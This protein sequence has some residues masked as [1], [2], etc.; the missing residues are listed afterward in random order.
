MNSRQPTESSNEPVR[1]LI[2]ARRMRFDFSKVPRYW[3]PGRP[4]ETHLFNALNAL[5]PPGEHLFIRVCLAVFDEVQDPE[6]RR[7]VRGFLAQESSHASGHLMLVPHLEAQ[8]FPMRSLIETVER[9]AARGERFLGPHRHLALVA[10]LEHFTATLGAWAFES[11]VFEDVDPVMRDLFLWHA[12]E[13]IE[14]KCVAF[15]LLQ[16]V[17]PG[18]WYRVLGLVSS[19][20]GLFTE[21]A[22]ITGAL[23]RSDPKV[24]SPSIARDAYRSWRQGRLPIGAILRGALRYLH[25]RFH[26]RHEANLHLALTYFDTAS[27]STG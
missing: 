17:R 22:W 9:R 8:G 19:M 23:I 14:H 7:D 10:G 18:Y 2:A 6:L 26:P 5:F 4:F 13:E 27:S 11:G 12:A 16:A 21:W 15:D 25:P 24:T 20:F 3:V 1:P